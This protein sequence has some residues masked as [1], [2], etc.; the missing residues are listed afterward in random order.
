[1]VLFNKCVHINFLKVINSKEKMLVYKDDLNKI[2]SNIFSDPH[3]INKLCTLDL[4][5]H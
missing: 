5:F 2:A 3:V 4:L 1:M